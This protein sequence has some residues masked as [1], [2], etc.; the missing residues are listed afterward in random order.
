[1]KPDAL[2]A[3]IEG[4]YA[5]RGFVFGKETQTEEALLNHTRARVL[6]SQKRKNIIFNRRIMGSQSTGGQRF[7]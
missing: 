5:L 1:M 3:A 7:M 6:T 2:S 4:L